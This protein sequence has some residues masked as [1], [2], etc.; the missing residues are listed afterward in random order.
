LP[1]GPVD[2]G[3]CVEWKSYRVGACALRRHPGIASLTGRA[4]VGRPCAAANFTARFGCYPTPLRSPPG[5]TE[6]LGRGTFCW[7]ERRLTCARRTVTRSAAPTA[8]RCVCITC[9]GPLLRLCHFFDLQTFAL[10]PTAPTAAPRR[11]QRAL[12]G[13]DEAMTPKPP[14]AAQGCSSSSLTEM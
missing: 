9:A 6:V 2:C 7:A 8:A 12:G 1:L 11:Y 10:H 14:S 4:V 5:Y 13:T 3:D